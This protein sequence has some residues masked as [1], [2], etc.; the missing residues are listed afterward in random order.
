MAYKLLFGSMPLRLDD[1][2]DERKE[3]KDG[4]VRHKMSGYRVYIGGMVKM[5]RHGRPLHPAE[6][7]EPVSEVFRC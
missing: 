7:R 3:L 2:K 4:L 6:S 1:K 5:K